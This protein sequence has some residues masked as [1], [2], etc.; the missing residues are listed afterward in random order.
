MATGKLR[1]E[2]TLNHHEEN[3]QLLDAYLLNM[4][5]GNRSPHSIAAYRYAIADFLDFTLGLGVAEITHREITEWLHF[6][7]VRDVS[8]RTS[9]SRL[10]AL[11]SFFKYAQM[12][13]VLKDSP[14]RLIE[15]RGVP[16]PLPHW[17]SVIDIRKLIAAAENPRD[18]ALVEFMYA[19][20]CRVA[21]VVGARIE[22]IHWEMRTVKVLGKGS[23]ERLVPLGKRAVQTLRDYLGQREA[24]AV[25]LSEEP[26]QGPQAQKGGVSCDRYGAWRGYWRATDASGKRTMRSV[27]LG[28]YEIATKEQA[29]AALTRHLASKPIPNPFDP[30]VPIT[31]RSVRRTLRELGVK[32]GIGKVTPHMLRHS[33]ATHLLEGGADLRSIQMLLGHESILTTQIYTHCSSVH[34][35][36]ALEKAHPSWQEESH[37]EN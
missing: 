36:K 25:F 11:R 12:T 14:A 3:A 28:D 1:E 34:L 27:K 29:Q 24:G 9:C 19:T 2:R 10:G 17:L 4:E 33:F 5:A 20:G 26:G 31:A 35:R 7:K 23:K 13:G 22:N 8:P 16:R 21:E 32:A 37:E 18:R 30:E 15:S 6:L